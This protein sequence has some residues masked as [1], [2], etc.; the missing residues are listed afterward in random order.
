METT[1]H[2]PIRLQKDTLAIEISKGEL[3]GLTYRGKEFMHKSS[4]PGWGHS[5]TEMFPIIGPTAE[6]AYR[7]QVPRGNA[8]LDQHGLLREM[9]YTVKAVSDSEVV[10]EK[11]YK[12]GTPIQNSKFPER[13]QLRMQIWPFDFQFTKKVSLHPDRVKVS[14]EVRGEKDM[15][16]MLGYHP[17]F[18][19]RSEKARVVAA[20]QS[21][22]MDEIMGV[23][24]RALH[25]PDCNSL[26]LE[27][28]ER[29]LELRTDG[30]QS[31]M[32]WSPDPGMLCIEP[33]TFYPYDAGTGK[34]HEGF[35]HLGDAP[36]RFSLTILLKDSS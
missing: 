7:V 10:L 25:V 2:P 14:F 16:F 9:S 26:K 13:S 11:S 1:E 32:L 24:D 27:D 29:N 28:G 20:D 21:F 5:D 3:T 22:D 30:F 6:T 19:I 17:A 36:Q 35:G 4:E 23:G 31:F 8:L 18:A 34:L 33:I 12:A 15:P